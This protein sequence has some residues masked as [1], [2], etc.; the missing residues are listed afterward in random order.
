M[1]VSS[2]ICL[3]KMLGA[4]SV[5]KKVC[6]GSPLSKSF[7]SEVIFWYT[8]PPPL[9]YTHSKCGGAVFSLQSHAG[10]SVCSH[11]QCMAGAAAVSVLRV[12]IG[13][14]QLV[15]YSPVDS[16]EVGASSRGQS[17]HIVHTDLIP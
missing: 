4:K 8:M 11:L 17:L 16:L 1:P 3:Q 6:I 14:N 9:V 15:Y 10:E 12:S 13:A 5:G 2:G 7:S